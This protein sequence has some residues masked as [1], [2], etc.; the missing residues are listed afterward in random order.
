M[1][2]DIM[3]KLKEIDP[4]VIDG[5]SQR[6][7]SF[8]LEDTNGYIIDGL[9]QSFDYT[10]DPEF[11]SDIETTSLVYMWQ[12]GIDDVYDY[13]RKL[14]DV[15]QVFDYL[16]TRDYKSICWIH[17]LP[18]EWH[19]LLNI[20]DFDDVFARK[21]HKPMK[22]TY[23]N[24]EFRCTFQLTHQ[25]LDALGKSLGY[26]K[27]KDFNYDEIKTPNT[28]LTSEEV[29]YGLRDI[30]IIY[31]KIK[32]MKKEYGTL[33][34]IPMTQT[35]IPRKV[36]KNMYA[37]DMRFHKKMAELLPKNAP[38]YARLRKAF[39]GGWVHSNYFYVGVNLK[40][41][42]YAYDI[43]SSYPT[44][45]VLQKY[46]MSRWVEA[47]PRDFE[48]F[49]EDPE[50]LTYMEVTL[51]NVRSSGFNDFLS[52]SKAYDGV[53][54]KTENGRIYKADK[55]TVTCT[56]ID[57]KIM[58]E[59]YNAD[60]DIKRLWYATA[61]YLDIKYVE[62]VL[63][64]YYDKVTLTGDPEKKEL[65]DRSKEKLNSLFGMEV[66]AVVYDDCTWNGNEWNT[67]SLTT[68]EMAEHIDIELSNLRSKCYKLI[69]SYSHGVFVT[70]YGRAALWEII[71]QVNKKVV[72]HDTDSVYAIG[73]QS[74]IINKYN[75]NIK[76]ML[77]DVCIE[78][79]IDPERVHPKT[80]DGEECWLGVYTCDND[81]LDGK[82]FAEF[83]T[84]GS[85]RY[86]YRKKKGDPIKITVAGVNKKEGVKQLHDDMDEFKD[87][88]TFDYDT[89][90]KLIPNYNMFQPKST[91]VDRDGK[92]YVSDYRFG[93]T[94]QPTRYSLSLGQQFIDTLSSLGSLSSLFSE[95]DIDQL[96]EIDK[97][98]ADY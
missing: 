87:G 17:N 63:S 61:G 26:P 86:A 35:G 62:E 59:A 16:A 95:L 12:F 24:L 92:T 91:W 47:R 72:Y 50:Y 76:K 6:V 48:K 73:D 54:V 4:L 40:D 45:M 10:K 74:E 90:K 55:F 64:L 20:I 69:T 66:S 22:A 8:D 81:E 67:P 68:K 52:C 80:P 58:K 89:C 27:Q 19:F 38:E 60:F 42:V 1:V 70:A 30:E 46:P 18:H 15:K 33:Q 5:Y 41:C 96:D 9:A 97:E 39:V 37:K 88:M 3:K 75:E 43:T 83:K 71:K 94:L 25:S 53:N 82:P 11:Y 32:R 85:K 29:R 79:G 14:E 31:E 13:D 44:Q 65:R 51:S 2:K 57:Y 28:Q 7:Y 21:P 98:E 56:E 93:I 78:R 23:G 49:I 34:E 36:V 77:T 84:L